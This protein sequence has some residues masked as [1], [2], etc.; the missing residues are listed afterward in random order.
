[1]STLGYAS[2]TNQRFSDKPNQGTNDPAKGVK[3][4]VD[5]LSAMVP[6]EVLAAHAVIINFLYDDKTEW[7]GHSGTQIGGLFALLVIL[8]SLLFVAPRLLGGTAWMRGDLVRALIPPAAFI[9]WSVLQPVS[10][11]DGWCPDLDKQMSSAVVIV[12]A[13]GLG[14]LTSSLANAAAAEPTPAQ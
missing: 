2:L 12:L 9:G 14:I 13:I 10:L 4:Y 7:V 6:A 1:M 3:T 5:A 8:S 11:L